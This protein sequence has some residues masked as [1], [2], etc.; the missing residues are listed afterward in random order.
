MTNKTDYKY[1]LSIIFGTLIVAS[2]GASLGE[3]VRGDLNVTGNLTANFIY[4]EIWNYSS[5]GNEWT[6]S[7][8]DADVYYNFT[9]LNN[10]GL[11]G[12]NFSSSVLTANVAGRYKADFHLSSELSLGNSNE[13]SFAIVKNYDIELSRNCY[14]RRQLASG[15]VG[16]VS[17]TCFVDLDVGDTVNIQIENED[18]N[19]NIDVHSANLN[20]IRI[21]D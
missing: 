1:I 19:R 8:V 12:F 13:F 14:A 15:I 11:N 3:I 9:N 6:F 18:G 21:G 7:I 5:S 4:A 20:I 17:V 16:S 10:A 2:L